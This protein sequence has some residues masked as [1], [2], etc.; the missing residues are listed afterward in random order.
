MLVLEAVRPGG[1]RVVL[2]RA[3]AAASEG[4][5]DTRLAVGKAVG[6]V[7]GRAVGKVAGKAG[8]VAGSEAECLAAAS[9]RS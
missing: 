8:R 1:K 7:V 6:R 5:A 2:A 4:T 3:V 9:G